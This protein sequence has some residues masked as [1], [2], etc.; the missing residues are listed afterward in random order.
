MN[1]EGKT[2]A[3][4]AAEQTRA[5]QALAQAGAEMRTMAKQSRQAMADQAKALREIVKANGTLKATFDKVTRITEE[6]TRGA[7]E[8]AQAAHR[9]RAIPRKPP[10]RWPNKRARS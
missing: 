2:I 1:E 5:T 4:A 3:R 9:M 6:Q 8:L 10:Q 7:V